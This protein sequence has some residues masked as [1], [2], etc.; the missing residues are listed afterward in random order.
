MEVGVR[1]HQLEPHGGRGRGVTNGNPM[2]VGVRGRQ[3]EPH[4]GRGHGV[5]GVGVAG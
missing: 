5:M 4:G 3:L 1:G 2:E